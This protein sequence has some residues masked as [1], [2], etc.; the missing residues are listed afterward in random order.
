M[1]TALSRLIGWA[2]S[3]TRSNVKAFAAA[4]TA[5]FIRVGEGEAG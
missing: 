3:D 1:A 2:R 4:A 5:F